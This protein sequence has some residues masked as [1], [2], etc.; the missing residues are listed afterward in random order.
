MRGN[1]ARLNLNVDGIW[2]PFG[3]SHSIEMCL[4]VSAHMCT[5]IMLY[6]PHAVTVVLTCVWGWENMQK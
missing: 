6:S 1:T 4:L 5:E 3:E 2:S